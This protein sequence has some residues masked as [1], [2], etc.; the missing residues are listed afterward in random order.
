MKK[1][2]KSS[3]TILAV[4]CL[5]VTS[6]FAS[7]HVVYDTENEDWDAT[8]VEDGQEGI[9]SWHECAGCLQE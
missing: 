4:F 8:W 1:I 6:T 3:L 9:G 5:A 2:I 7:W